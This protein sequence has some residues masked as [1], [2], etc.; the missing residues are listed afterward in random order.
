MKT[1]IQVYVSHQ[2]YKN[3]LAHITHAVLLTRVYA[4]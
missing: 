4:N 1:F 3:S 2:G